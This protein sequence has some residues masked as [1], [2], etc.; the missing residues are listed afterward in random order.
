M[1]T[2]DRKQILDV[3][4]DVEN[5]RAIDGVRPLPKWLLM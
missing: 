3:G 4:V 5:T 1:W 2:T